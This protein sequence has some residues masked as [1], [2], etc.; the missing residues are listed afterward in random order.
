[1][2]KIK[3]DPTKHLRRSDL[4]PCGRSHENAA[5]SQPSAK[6]HERDFLTAPIDE[7]FYIDFGPNSQLGLPQGKRKR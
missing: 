4:G 1:M 5:A 7:A 6:K 3:N 2:S